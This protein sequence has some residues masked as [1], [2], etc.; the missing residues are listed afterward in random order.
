MDLETKLRTSNEH[1]EE[2]R[3]R[4]EQVKKD[5]IAL[6]KTIDREKEATMAK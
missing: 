4:F 2:F 5:M 6:K 3:R 1:K